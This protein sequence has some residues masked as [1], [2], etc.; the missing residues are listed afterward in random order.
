[1]DSRAVLREPDPPDANFTRLSDRPFPRYRFVPGL[2]PHPVAHPDGHSYGEEP[3]ALVAEAADL[4]RDW[5]LS[6]HYRF[7]IDLYNFAY[8]WEA[9]ETWE[10]LWRCFAPGDPIR[11]ALQAMIQVSA[12]QLK[13]HVGQPR[14]VEALLERVRGHLDLARAA[15][16]FML[17]VHLQ[18]WWSSVVLP[19]FSGVPGSAYPWLVPAAGEQVGP[20]LSRRRF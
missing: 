11:H 5:R 15:G 17:G 2:N 6:P 7:G 10:G 20:Q 4:R 1:M 14:G 8:W 3:P 9:H 16:P 13:R 19:W 18:A 12:A